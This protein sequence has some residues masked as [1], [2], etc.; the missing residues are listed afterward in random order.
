VHTIAIAAAGVTA[1]ASAQP[2]VPGY[3]VFTYAQNFPNG[4]NLDAAPDGAL[5]A[6]HEDN[7]TPTQVWRIAPGGGPASLF[8]D[9]PLLDPDVVAV[10]GA[11]G[12]SGVAGTV[13]VGGG[14]SVNPNMGCIWAVAPDETTS[15]LV[16]PTDVFVNVNDME[17]DALGRLLFIDGTTSSVY[18]ATGP[19]TFDT[20]FTI[21]SAVRS[22]ATA[23]DGRIFACGKDGIVRIHDADGMEI[24]PSFAQVTDPADIELPAGGDFD[25]ALYALE[26]STGDLL[27][28]DAEGTT[29]PIGTGFNTPARILFGVDQALYVSHRPDPGQGSTTVF[30]VLVCPPDFNSD[31]VLNILDFVAFQNAFGAGDG[32][33]DCNDDGSLDILDFV[34]FQAVFQQGC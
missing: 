26:R 5:F 11:G 29:T 10:D 31:G 21:T 28:I 27:A 18:V 33:A 17:M 6:G 15:T 13:L 2:V 3:S 24:D 4:V 25:A 19:Q 30:R 20:L 7:G 32:A 8:G 9:T 34:C 14:C 16:G 12:V 23:P 22:L 1:A